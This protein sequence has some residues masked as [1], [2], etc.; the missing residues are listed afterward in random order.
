MKS[1]RILG[2]VL[3]LLCVASTTWAVD[4]LTVVVDY[5]SYFNPSVQSVY[6]EFYCSIYRYQLEFVGP[7]STQ[8]Y[9]A[10][11]K[12]RLDILND[13]GAIIDTA[14]TFFISSVKDPEEKFATASRLFDYIPVQLP[15]GKYRAV[16]TAI[17][18]VSGK[19]GSA[20]LVCNVPDLNGNKL[21][22]SNI[23]LAYTIFDTSEAS[24]SAVNPRLVKEGFQVV[25]NPSTIYQYKID[26]MLHA[27]S[28][29]YG[30]SAVPE[31]ETG[32]FIV[33]YSVKDSLG[34]LIKEYPEKRYA[35][36][37]PSAVLTKELD[38]SD[39]E[40]GN[41]HILLE[42]MD[43]NTREM[44][45][46][47]KR[48]TIVDPGLIM[49]ATHQDTADVELMVNIAWYHLSEGEK[50]R[51]NDLTLNGKRNFIRQF[52]REMDD[53]PLTPE[54]P[55][56]DE[57]VRRFYHANEFFST[58]VGANDGWKTDR[59][60]VYIMYG[61]YDEISEFVLPGTADPMIKW[62][63]HGIEGGVLFLFAN[64]YMAGASDYRLVHSTHSREKFDP[65]WDNKLQQGADYID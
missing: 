28:E 35:K 7:D 25:P 16:V 6:T 45:V 61:P 43:G 17:D 42:A 46:A 27:Y 26:H 50:M 1:I 33:K 9:Y 57:A 36:A 23:E 5:A 37:G 64:D 31:G 8:H 34:T 3:C 47:L 51:I 56:Y 12:L 49:H 65:D 2:L 24:Y 21:Q 39:I 53:D 18:D 60:R 40:P 62:V 32:S 44:A 22:A 30:L 11:V 55:V 38:I 59:G 4:S 20:S 54:N 58:K 29:L 13:V 63:Y 48:F 10:A 14:S 41:Y 15:P 19:K 52:W